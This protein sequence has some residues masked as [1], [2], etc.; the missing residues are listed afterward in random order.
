MIINVSILV[1][2]TAWLLSLLQ[3]RGQPGVL[4]H[5]S[6]RG[7]VEQSERK[8]QAGHQ[9]EGGRMTET[10]DFIIFML[11]NRKILFLVWLLFMEYFLAAKAKGLAGIVSWQLSFCVRGN[12]AITTTLSPWLQTLQRDC[13]LTF[14]SSFLKKIFVFWYCTCEHWEEGKHRSNS[15]YITTFHDRQNVKS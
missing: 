3:H 12:G 11:I 5:H 6:H 4:L 13:G 10:L 14:F 7:A 9:G 2:F 1:V 15:I 8:H